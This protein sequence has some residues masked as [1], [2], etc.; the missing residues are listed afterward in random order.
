MENGLQRQGEIHEL[1]WIER[2]RDGRIMGVLQIDM[3]IGDHF[4]RRRLILQPEFA[5]III[6][7]VIAQ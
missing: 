2:L 5:Q 4:V 7:P 3:T 1:I 6:F